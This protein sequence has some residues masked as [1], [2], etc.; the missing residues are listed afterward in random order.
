MKH[1]RKKEAK[2]SLSLAALFL[3]VFVFFI[4]VSVCFKTFYL[5][6]DSKFDGT[7]SYNVEFVGP[8]SSSYVSFS[9]RE[10]SISILKVEKGAQVFAPIDG[11]ISTSLNSK[12][13]SSTLLKQLISPLSHDNLTIIDLVRLAFFA[14]TV[15]QASIEERSFTNQSDSRATFKDPLIE[16]EA[17]SIEIVNTTGVSGLGN[18][19]AAFISN[20]GGNV[21]LVKTEEKEQGSKIVYYGKKSYTLNRI[22]N[23]LNYKVVPSIKREVADVIIIIG[24]DGIKKLDF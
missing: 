11:K 6:K 10:K 17:K 22:N 2:N 3:V 21:I 9:P 7:N 4:F 12:N 20:M 8:D 16:Y 5:V 19:L 23:F 13:L 14:K 1:R 15:P 18:K 24:K